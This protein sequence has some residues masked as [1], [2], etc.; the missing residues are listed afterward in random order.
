MGFYCL[1]SK[2]KSY[3]FILTRVFNPTVG[4]LGEAHLY[5][6]KSKKF[7]SELLSFEANG[8][9]L[10]YWFSSILSMLTPKFEACM[11]TYSWKYHTKFEREWT[12]YGFFRDF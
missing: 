10:N 6:E 1:F 5:L 7:H 2:K 4:F 8:L 3:S 11:D 9:T 12:K